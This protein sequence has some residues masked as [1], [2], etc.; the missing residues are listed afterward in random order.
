VCFTAIWVSETGSPSRGNDSCLF[1]GYRSVASRH[2][3]YSAKPRNHDQCPRS[4]NLEE[5]DTVS[6]GGA[7]LLAAGRR[8]NE[9]R[10]R[11]RGYGADLTEEAAAHQR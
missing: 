3:L 5:K 6:L 1:Q 11:V 10:S 2:S 7:Y 8:T 4:S 9:S